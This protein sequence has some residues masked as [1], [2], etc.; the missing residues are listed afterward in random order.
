M[1][2]NNQKILNRI[3]III[4]GLL[5]VLSFL[6]AYQLRFRV[7]V[8]M[9]MFTLAENEY[10]YSLA[11]YA[12]NL[13][14][15][16]PAYLVIYSMCGLYRPKR[17]GGSRLQYWNLLKANLFG[18]LVF[19]TVLYGMKENDIAR[20]MI[21]VIFPALNYTLDVLFRLLLERLLRIMRR[22][23]FNQKHVLI[24]GY[25]RTAEAYIDRIRQNPQW[26]Y[27]IYGILDDTM[28]VGTMYKKAAVIGNCGELEK[29]LEENS[30]DEIVVTLSITEYSKLEML[31]GICEKTGVHTKFIPDYRSIIP[32]VP[33]TEDMDGLPVINIRNVPLND[34]FNRIIKRTFD[35]V[36]GTLAL[37]IALIPMAVIA[38]IIKC[39][40]EGPVLFSQVRVG[41]H[42]KEFKMY[43]FRSMTV[44]S[45]ASEKK[46]WTT[47]ND[48]RVTKI[49]RIIRK[50]SLDELPQLFNVLKGDMSLIGPRPERPYFVEKFK[51]EIPRYMIKHQVRPGM[52]GW[53]QVNGYRGDTSIRKRIECDLYYIENWSLGLDIKIMFMTVF[54]GF[55]NKNAY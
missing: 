15:L 41:L 46:A 43:K 6:A 30:F 42:N 34:L 11:Y 54:K 26:G 3:H 35:L 55:I 32:T 39:T 25:S 17:G 37:L 31:V 19:S 7:L 52:S 12:K 38:V 1:I 47:A 51:K 33:V 18:M 21:F 36:C 29:I 5:I 53:A 8:H 45:E 20:G 44:Q 22:K 10:H 2:K 49:G 28:E 4:D 27:H 14:Y 50:T 9:P 23:G 48:A 40:S 13:Y 16:V 24:V